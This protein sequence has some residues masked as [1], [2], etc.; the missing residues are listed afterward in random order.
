[1]P[2]PPLTWEKDKRGSGETSFL[3][4]LT[5]V[6]YVRRTAAFPVRMSR[7]IHVSCRAIQAVSRLYPFGGFVTKQADNRESGQCPCSFLLSAMRISIAT[8]FGVVWVP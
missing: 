5:D 3:L 1:M 2:L 6:P 7:A 4:C 8:S